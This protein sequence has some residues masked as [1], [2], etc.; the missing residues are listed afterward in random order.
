MT[1]LY[2]VDAF[3]DVPFKGNPAAVCITNEAQAEQWMKNVASEMNLSE[4]AFLCRQP[5][6]YRLR[7][8]T[9]K[10]EVSLCGHATLASAHILWQEQMV[11]P[12]DGIQFDTMGGVLIARKVDTLI[13][14]DFPARL[15]VPAP[16]NVAL[17]RALGVAP[18][19]TGN[20]RTPKGMIY[21]LELETE[22]M[23]RELKPDFKSLAET[24]ARAVMVTARSS[25]AEQDFVSRYFAPAVGIDED[26]V[27]GSAHCCLAPYWCAK[28]GKKTLIGYQAS[29]RGGFVRCNHTGE[30]VYIQGSAVT[31]FKTE[32][33]V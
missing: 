3:T 5:K 11:S 6:G 4:T 9:P 27:T 33:I 23:V 24:E 2:H 15:T 29:Y 1:R 19:W 13:E 26:P 17:N 10:A 32:L 20:Y 31:V 7:W 16:S 30:R 8:F 12:N 21:L 14:L 28:L 25:T 18:K 22:A